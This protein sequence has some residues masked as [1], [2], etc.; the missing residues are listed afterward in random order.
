MTTTRAVE[1]DLAA[2]AN[3]LRRISTLQTEF[4]AFLSLRTLRR[5]HAQACW[6]VLREGMWG[7]EEHLHGVQVIYET[8]MIFLIGRW[9][10]ICLYSPVGELCDSA[11]VCVCVWSGSRRPR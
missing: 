8:I 2:M 1:N 3:D 6:N 11:R 7:L 10:L 5:P 9:R 4:G